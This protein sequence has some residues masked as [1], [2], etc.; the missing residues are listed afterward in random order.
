MFLGKAVVS[1]EEMS[2]KLQ[3][4]KAEVLRIRDV[5]FLHIAMTK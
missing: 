2:Q 1:A 3:R 4:K 5:P